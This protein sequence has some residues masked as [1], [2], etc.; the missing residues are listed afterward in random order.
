LA[1]ALPPDPGLPAVDFSSP[2]ARAA[3][4]FARTRGEPPF[5]RDPPPPRPRDRVWLH[6]LLFLATVASTTLVGASFYANFVTGLGTRRVNISVAALLIG[7]LWYSLPALLILGCH[8]MGHYFAC[9]YYGISATLPFFIPAPFTL[10]G[11]L[12]AVIR[13]REPLRTKRILFDVGVAGPLA[14]FAVLLPA[15]V[16]GISWSEIIRRPRGLDGVDFGEPML[17]QLVTRL[18]FGPLPN[19]WEINAHPMAFASIFG[20]LA[21]ALNLLPIGQLDGGHISFANLGARAKYVTY[22]TLGAALILGVTV[23]N[24]WLIWGL[25]IVILLFITGFEHPPTADEHEPLDRNRVAVTILAII[26]FALCFTPWP[27][28]PTELIGQ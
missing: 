13:I 20:L 9:R 8:E 14:G 5:D 23:S 22:A 24:S 1:D 16:L 21:T 15:M 18:F 11:T 25:I 28:T 17:F 10:F 26:I 6:V 27:I 3:D 19:G 12:G 2:T 4:D 7:G